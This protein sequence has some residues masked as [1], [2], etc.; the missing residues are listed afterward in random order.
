[1]WNCQ[2]L[3]HLTAQRQCLAFWARSSPRQQPESTDWGA[4]SSPSSTCS[5]SGFSASPPRQFG[6][7]YTG[8]YPPPRRGL[9]SDKMFVT[10][11]GQVVSFMEGVVN[12]PS[13][14]LVS[15]DDEVLQ[16]QR[17]QALSTSDETV[18]Q[19]IRTYEA[20]RGA[21][22]S[23]AVF[24]EVKLDEVQETYVQQAGRPSAVEAA[25]CC[26]TLL[27]MPGIVGCYKTLLEKVATGI[28]AAVYLPEASPAADASVPPAMAAIVRRF[29][30]RTPYFARVR[31]LEKALSSSRS[32]SDPSVLRAISSDDVARIFQYVPFRHVQAGLAK[33]YATN[34]SMLDQLAD[35]L[36]A[37]QG[38]LLRSRGGDASP[39]D[40]EYPVHVPLATSA[41]ICRAIAQHAASF[42]S[43]GRDMILCAILEYVDVDS[44]RDVFKR[45]DTQGKVCFLHHLSLLESSDQLQMVVDA[46]PNAGESLFR[47]Y[48]VAC[49]GQ[50][51]GFSG[52]SGP[53]DQ[54][55]LPA[56]P[57]DVF[58]A[59]LLSPEMEFFF[60]CDL[61]TYLSGAQ[62]QMLS[63]EVERNESERKARRLQQSSAKATTEFEADID[64]D[65]SA[66]NA[67]Q[68][69]S[70]AAS[71]DHFQMMMWKYLRHHT[72]SSA[73]LLQLVANTFL[74]ALEEKEFGQLLDSCWARF[75]LDGQWAKVL[76]VVQD[77]DTGRGLSS[78]SEPPSASQPA[79]NNDY[80]AAI[81]L[82]L[83]KKLFSM[84]S[85]EER[86]AWMDRMN[87]KHPTDNY[88]KKLQELK[89]AAAVVVTSAP[90]DF[91]DPA[92]HLAFMKADL[93][94]RWL[95]AIMESLL[96][97][98][99]HSAQMTQLKQTL[100]ASRT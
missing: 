8:G 80:I 57:K 40:P 92:V 95:E 9:A 23:F 81:R 30:S 28:Q 96:S 22:A 52:E 83:V 14:A 79:V 74:S 65:S 90:P 58:F 41:Q 89:N 97:D 10:C 71:L 91:S 98:P 78:P 86:E 66:S 85:R 25:A 35:A 17:L 21:F 55:P 13:G 53:S 69:L 31:E 27:K 70:A 15:P 61:A 75:P 16:L 12:A 11:G 68:T 24:T 7:P 49:T 43:S 59:N 67:A 99:A 76:A 33:V 32:L 2:D 29:Y 26:A 36:R 56:N 93:K 73:Q 34:S 42:S 45:F 60:L 63:R 20:E 72:L 62:W 51:G 77:L 3:K 38:L 87:A 18:E 46:L 5:S 84:L 39:D 100:Q 82:K 47:L 64:E 88:K 44:F 50:G 94:M 48:F 37:Q 19:W 6:S 54:Q 1:M 4:V